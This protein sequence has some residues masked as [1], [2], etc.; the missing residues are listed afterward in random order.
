MKDLTSRTQF[1]TTKGAKPISF[2]S[3]SKT[4]IAV[5]GKVQHPSF[6]LGSRVC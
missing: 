2:A 1:F 6:F 5:G 4:K 3:T